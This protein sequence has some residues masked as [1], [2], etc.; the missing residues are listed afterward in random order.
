[1]NTDKEQQLK[2][3]L[4]D[5][6]IEDTNWWLSR[7]KAS[8]APMAEIALFLGELWRS[9]IRRDDTTWVQE[10]VDQLDEGEARTDL[11]ALR[12]LPRNPELK[13]ALLRVS[14]ADIDLADLTVIVRELQI[15]VLSQTA[16]L[17]D[18]GQCFED[19][20]SDNWCLCSLDDELEPDSCFGDIKH[21]VWDFDP[22]REAEAELP[23]VED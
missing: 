1:M 5:A 13:N 3:V 20:L 21:L 4:T 15:N 9:V 11:Y 22:D 23:N 18:G 6:K 2:Q 19:G 12:F 17:L 14:A 7:N 8:D 16:D 10:L